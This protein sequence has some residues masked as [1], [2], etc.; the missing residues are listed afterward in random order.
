M[1]MSMTLSHNLLRTIADGSVAS[2]ASDKMVIHLVQVD[3]MPKAKRETKKSGQIPF[4]L[5]NNGTTKVFRRSKI[6]KKLPRRFAKYRHST[7]VLRG[8]P[9]VVL[10]PPFYRRPAVQNFTIRPPAMMEHP[11]HVP[12]API[13]M[14]T[15]LPERLVV[16]D[17]VTDTS[18]QDYSTRE[19]DPG[20]SPQTTTIAF[21]SEFYSEA[22]SVSRDPPTTTTSAPSST[23]PEPFIEWREEF[24]PPSFALEPPQNIDNGFTLMTYND[25]NISS[26]EIVQYL[27]PPLWP[28]FDESPPEDANRIKNDYPDGNNYEDIVLTTV[29]AAT[30][31]IRTETFE[32]LEYLKPPDYDNNFFWTS[33]YNESSV[34]DVNNALT[35]TVESENTHATENKS[36]PFMDV[37]LSLLAS[38]VASMGMKVE[39]TAKAIEMAR[40]LIRSRSGDRRRQDTELPLAVAE[41]GPLSLRDRNFAQSKPTAHTVRTSPK[42]KPYKRPS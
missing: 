34:F 38:D 7:R 20:P 41:S 26:P 37:N 17:P 8:K 1:L 29:T 30:T 19:S 22:T 23:E 2:A 12:V 16:H 18:P 39:A 11:V 14:P 24:Q 32:P 33:Y 31:T 13:D 15:P 27:L 10:L 40:D 21:T 3:V 28:E 6:R 9:A 36:A 25:S 35:A 4:Q 5:R 42:K